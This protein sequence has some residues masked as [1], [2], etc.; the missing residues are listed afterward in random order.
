MHPDRKEW[1]C[2][3]NL[4]IGTNISLNKIANEHFRNNLYSTNKVN[5]TLY[6]KNHMLPKLIFNK[7]KFQLTHFSKVNKFNYRHSK[8]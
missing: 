2:E 1:Q 6:K 4:F 8:N 5:Q 3:M 7:G